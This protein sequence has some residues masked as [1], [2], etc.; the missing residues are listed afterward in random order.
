MFPGCRPYECASKQC[1]P[2]ELDIIYEEASVGVYEI[3]TTPLLNVLVAVSVRSSLRLMFLNIVVPS[4]MTAG[5]TRKTGDGIFCRPET[6]QHLVCYASKE[7]CAC[8][9]EPFD[10][11][12]VFFRA[13]R[14][15]GEI[16]V[17]TFKVAVKRYEIEDR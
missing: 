8:G 2:P 13:V 15:S 11:I 6:C 9:S 16:S 7:K 3:R 1:Q 12:F 17:R 5:S 4:P 10:G 14:M